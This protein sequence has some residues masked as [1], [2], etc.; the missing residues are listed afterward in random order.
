MTKSYIHSAERFETTHTCGAAYAMPS[1]LLGTGDITQVN[2]LLY[3]DENRKAHKL[4]FHR[5]DGNII[6]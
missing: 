2:Q 4:G 6:V 1:R 5:W 3:V